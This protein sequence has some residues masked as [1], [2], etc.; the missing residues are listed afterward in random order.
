M[1]EQGLPD[2]LNLIKASKENQQ[3]SLKD[4]IA[5]LFEQKRTEHKIL[6]ELVELAKALQK[7]SP[8]SSF[9]TQPVR[10]FSSRSANF[11]NTIRREPSTKS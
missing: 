9:T 6:M 7:V 4:A 3:Q 10:S 2:G 1:I 5:Q 8:L 11:P